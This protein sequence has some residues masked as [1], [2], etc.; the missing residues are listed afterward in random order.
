MI[1]F[2]EA[3]TQLVAK[4]LEII[5]QVGL[6]LWSIELI[7]RNIAIFGNFIH[8]VATKRIR[9][10]KACQDRQRSEYSETGYMDPSDK[11]MSRIAEN[12]SNS[13]M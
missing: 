11:N 13:D 10:K 2:F 1:P 6:F 12:K 9:K 7:G 5:D 4:A 8:T 3:T